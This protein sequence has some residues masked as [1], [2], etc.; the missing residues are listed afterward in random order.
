MHGRPERARTNVRLVRR[1]QPRSTRSHALP[2]TVTIVVI[3][4]F[5][6][7][8]VAR[9]NDA[10]AAPIGP[11]IR[12]WCRSRTLGMAPRRPPWLRHHLALPVLHR[13]GH[14]RRR[15]PHRLRWSCPR[16][17]SRRRRRCPPAG[18]PTSPP[19][20]RP[21][22]TGSARSS[23]R[24]ADCRR[25][26]CRRTSWRCPGLVCPAV[27]PFGASRSRISRRSPWP[28]GRPGCD[29]RSSRPT[30]ARPDSA[31]RSRVGYVPQEKLRQNVS[32]RAPD[33]RSISSGPPS[34]SRPRAA[35]PRG[36]EHSHARGMRDGWR[37]TPGGS[38]GS[39]A[40]RRVRRHRPATAMRPGTT[41]TSDGMSP[42]RSTRR[43]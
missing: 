29:S 28:G 35:G 42:P 2:L 43:G 31:R 37:P 32:V 23:I 36:R 24:S 41:A 26:T 34:I 10:G 19:P 15:P 1:A 14:P 11:G 33:T 12:P 38:A 9:A 6:A 13:R 27:A 8:F 21:T 25:A 22:T 4:V 39:R 5:V 18:T 17:P 3:A 20:T 30:G 7:T 40:I 16:R